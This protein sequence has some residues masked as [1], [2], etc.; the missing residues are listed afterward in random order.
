MVIDWY[1]NKIQAIDGVGHP[2]LRDASVTLG[3]YVASSYLGYIDAVELAKS[4]I[5][6]NTYLQ[7]GISGYQKTAI[8]S[9]NVGMSK[10]IIFN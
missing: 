6:Q 7:K 4:L 5:S 10:P 3:G 2:I 1:K 8:Q 9:I